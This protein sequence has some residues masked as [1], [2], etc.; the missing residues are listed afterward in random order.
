MDRLNTGEK[1]AGISGVLLLIIMFLFDWFTIDVGGGA[2]N[3]STGGNAWESFGFIDLV[4]FLA[5]V[6]GIALAAVASSQSKPDLPV[7]ISAITTGIGALGVL[8]VLF[9]ILSPPDFG[10]GDALDVGRGIGVFLGLIAVAGVAYGGWVAMQEE[11]S[12]VSGPSDR[13]GGDAPPPS[14]PPPPPPPS[15]GAPGGPPAQ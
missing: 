7:A 5:A 6:A 11:G 1:I 8:L 10:V 12:S 14:P 15:G 3:V 9:R 13:V 2:F 4:L